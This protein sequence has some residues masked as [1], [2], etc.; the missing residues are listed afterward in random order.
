MPPFVLFLPETASATI[1][2]GGVTYRPPLIDSAGHLQVDVLTSALPSGA[3][4]SAKQ[5]T[6]ITA[7]Q[8]IDDLRAA[9][10]AVQADRLNVNVYRD[11]ASEVKAARKQT[12]GD[13][14][15]RQTAVTPTAGK[16]IR[17][18]SCV[19]FTN[20]ATANRFEVYFGT[21]AS[22]FTTA[23]KEIM[24]SYLDMDNQA[25]FGMVWPDGGGPVG[26]VDDV[27]SLRTGVDISNLA[28]VLIHYRE[29]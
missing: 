16:K 3:A 12:V 26:A 8:L 14:T 6:M 4:T 20:S 21:G 13:S 7:L 15:T 22:I 28:Y 29:E 27:V 24:E 25:T 5:D 9:L 10:D 19:C 2:I 18:V 17:V 11:G 23:G 1:V